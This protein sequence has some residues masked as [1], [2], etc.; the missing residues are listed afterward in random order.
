MHLG[1]RPH[2]LDQAFDAAEP[3]PRGSRHLPAASQK[4]R[5][6]RG[7]QPDPDLDADILID[8]L[9]ALDHLA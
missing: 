2:R 3:A 8:N 7:L 1:R 5:G 9:H 4:F 6:A